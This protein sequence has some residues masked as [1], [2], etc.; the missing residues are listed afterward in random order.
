MV[1]K[2]II[3]SLTFPEFPLIDP[4]QFNR[5][6]L[7]QG[8]YCRFYVDFT[9][10]LQFFYCYYRFCRAHRSKIEDMRG[11]EGLYDNLLEEADE[12]V[13]NKIKYK[14]L[15]SKICENGDNQKKNGSVAYN[16]Q[17]SVGF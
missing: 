12:A 14:E 7:S 17:H 6:P 2:L 5:E 16:T 9:K 11:I 13:A 4:N 15:G 8:N 3:L 10:K 1:A